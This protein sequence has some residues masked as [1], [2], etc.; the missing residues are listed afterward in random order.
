MERIYENK[1]SN[2]RQSIGIIGTHHGVG[3]TY[4]ALMLAFYMGEELGK[5]TALLECN[6]HHD[7][8][9]IQNAYEWSREEEDSFSFHQITCYKEVTQDYLP[10]LLGMSYESFI[11]DFG[12]DYAA[13]REELLRCTNKI[14]IGGRTQWEQQKLIEFIETH[15]GVDNNE[16]WLYLI[17]CAST[18]TIRYLEGELKHLVYSVPFEKEPTLLSKDVITLFEKLF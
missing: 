9:R 14:V 2:S 3:V 5:R 16:G 15:L 10:D 7:M 11:L 8:G 13:N 4:T 12:T 6:N 17:P 1:K 18:R